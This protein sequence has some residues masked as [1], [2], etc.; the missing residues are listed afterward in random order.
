MKKNHKVRSQIALF[1]VGLILTATTQATL[2]GH[3]TFDETSGTNAV[4][5]SG[6]GYDGTVVNPVWTTNGVIGGAL[7]MNG[8][9]CE[10]IGFSSN[11]LSTVTN[12]I[13]IS[14]WARG[15]LA[16]PQNMNGFSGYTGSNRIL[17][18][19]LPTGSTIYWDA[20]KTDATDRIQKTGGSLTRGPWRHWA[21]TKN[22]T[23][24]TMAIYMDGALWHDSGTNLMVRTMEGVEE[25]IIG[26]AGDSTRLHKGLMDDFRV[27]DNELDATAISNLYTAVTLD[28]AIAHFTAVP[29]GGLIP[30]DVVFDGSSSI[31]STNITDYAW[32]FG[33][34]NTGN[35][36]IV[37]N[38]F[39]VVGTNTV[40]LSVTDESGN[41]DTS[42]IEIV[43]EPALV[44][45]PIALGDVLAIDFGATPSAVANYNDVSYDGSPSWT[46]PGLVRLADGGTTLVSLDVAIDGTADRN[47]GG[48]VAGNGGST[49]ASICEDGIAT[50]TGSSGANN[51]SI[52]LTFTGLDDDLA[53]NI[54]GGAARTALI[55]SFSTDWTIGSFT[56][57]SD[58]TVSSGYVT[59]SNMRSSEGELVITITDPV[60]RVGVAQVE[61]TAVTP[62]D[63]IASF[64]ATPTSGRIP[65]DVVFDASASV[66]T[67]NI[68]DYSWNFGDGNTGNGM[69]ATNTYTVV[70]NNTV[71]LTV[72][73]ANGSTDT[74]V[75]QVVAEPALVGDPIVVGDVLAIDFGATDSTVA[76]YNDIDYPNLEIEGLVR[77]ADGGGTFVSLEVT[78]EGGSQRDQGGY[79]AGNGGSTDA[80]ICGDGIAL[81]NS[82]ANNN[83]ITLTF[84]GLNDSLT[85]DIVGGSSRTDEHIASFST[86]WTIGSVTNHSDCTTTNG[87]VTFTN[88]TS[89]AG[90][91]VI[92]ITDPVYRVG[93]AQVEL[94]AVGEIQADEPTLVY[95]GASLTWNS[96]V[97]VVYSVQS[98]LNLS[99]ESSWGTFDTVI[100][101]PPTT[102][103]I[104]P[105]QNQ[106]AEFYR[107][108]VE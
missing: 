80:S 77:L 12:E 1:V 4:D 63:A 7:E 64:T 39:T 90:T 103:Y 8:T 34:G 53:Y 81:W 71:M 97:E 101:T 25:F 52:T 23:T 37:T 69:I 82:G 42:E 46:T 75:L 57:H 78:M 65:L 48:Y 67:T 21:F 30:F 58:C 2:V 18:G 61:L 26:S 45:D 66:S 86:D 87:Y 92:T 38:T 100:G 32:D 89:S 24:G 16:D 60:Y 105:P 84:T 9:D 85:Y 40:T 35:G 98:N 31:S 107:V 94:T 95:D 3:W 43:A 28:Y 27:Y 74:A 102:S 14:F 83:S 108:I 5:S 96:N 13:T 19:H 51:N 88:M 17:N 93:V 44:G 106:N 20:G 10:V 68:T 41:T 55:E 29:D 76:N 104:L 33:D 73:D 49:D 72:T 54:V 70:G 56:K 15:D 99:I 50:W 36:M 91:L 79:V 6:N 22:A 47:Q 59:F 11:L 62:N